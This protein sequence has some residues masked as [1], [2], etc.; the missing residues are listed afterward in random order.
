MAD[1]A[2]AGK[3]TRKESTRRQSKEEEEARM[4]TIS[5]KHSQKAT[6]CVPPKKWRIEPDPEEDVNSEF[7]NV[8]QEP[9]GSLPETPPG[10]IYYKPVWISGIY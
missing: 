7:L 5:D 6:G 10:W 3:W 2:G 4:S 1:L 8:P 9:W